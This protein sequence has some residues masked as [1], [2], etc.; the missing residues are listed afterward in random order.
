LPSSR[1]CNYPMI[2]SPEP[3]LQLPGVEQYCHGFV[4][5]RPEQVRPRRGIEFEPQCGSP[6]LVVGTPGFVG[7]SPGPNM[8]PGALASA[9]P[10]FPDSETISTSPS[11]SGDTVSRAKI[12]PLTTSRGLAN[13]WAKMLV[14]IGVTVPSSPCRKYG[15]HN[16]IALSWIDIWHHYQH[17]AN[18]CL[19]RYRTGR[20]RMPHPLR[21]EQTTVWLPIGISQR[22]LS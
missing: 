1:S 5:V 20:L 12:R 19:G 7:A 10:L 6:S 3:E 8:S 9:V 14:I 4:L 17:D 13:T 18:S 11:S 22:L 15:D 21:I 16:G 2:L